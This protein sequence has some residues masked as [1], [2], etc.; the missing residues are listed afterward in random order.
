VRRVRAWW[1]CK[2]EPKDFSQNQPRPSKRGGWFSFA[3]KDHSAELEKSLEPRGKLIMG[4]RAPRPHA[5]DT[6]SFLK[7]FRTKVGSR[8]ALIAGES[9]R[10]P[11]VHGSWECFLRGSTELW[12]SKI[13]AAR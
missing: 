8:F 1:L 11:S 6:L 7:A 10:A 2:A 4:A 13:G 3:L 5:A 9:A 12:E